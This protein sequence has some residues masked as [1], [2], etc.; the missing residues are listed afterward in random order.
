MP[1]PSIHVF[2]LPTY[3]SS[4]CLFSSVF[5]TT[6]SREME[7]IDILHRCSE[8]NRAAWIAYITSLFITGE[9]IVSPKGLSFIFIFELYPVDIKG[10]SLFLYNRIFQQIFP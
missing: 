3:F 1:C 4:F 10:F 2:F 9:N 7:L 8:Y 5:P 6:H